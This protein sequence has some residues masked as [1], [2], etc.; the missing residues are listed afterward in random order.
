MVCGHGE[1]TAYDSL[2]TKLAKAKIDKSSRFTDWS[3]RP[4]SERQ[5]SYALSDVTHLRVVYEKLRASSR[6]P[7]ACPGSPRRW[8][9]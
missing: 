5:I 6:S 3:R 2:A 1:P 8:R 9:C 7:D 4:L